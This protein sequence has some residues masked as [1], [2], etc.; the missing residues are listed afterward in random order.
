MRGLFELTTD[1]I[2]ELDISSENG[3]DTLMLCGRNLIKDGFVRGMAFSFVTSGLFLA[4][5]A[6]LNSDVYHN[7]YSKYYV[8]RRNN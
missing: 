2:D 6:F 3:M 8:W 7:L 4:T 1:Q 5:S